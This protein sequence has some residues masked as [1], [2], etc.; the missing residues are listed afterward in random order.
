MTFDEKKK[1]AKVLKMGE[2]GSIFVEKAN[3]DEKT[4]SICGKIIPKG[5]C[6]QVYQTF[7]VYRNAYYRDAAHYCSIHKVTE[8]HDEDDPNFIEKVNPPTQA[9]YDHWKVFGVDP[10][11]IHKKLLVV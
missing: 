7:M 6:H 9:D 10:D 5:E 8:C 1:G 11:N 4:C 2:F 3:R